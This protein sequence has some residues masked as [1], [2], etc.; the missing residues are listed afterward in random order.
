MSRLDEALR[1]A[2][3]RDATP[4]EPPG[5]DAHGH[6]VDP[7]TFTS[8]W[9]FG[10]GVRESDRQI[11]LA[12][13]PADHGDPIR[14][15]Q[16]QP[17]APEAGRDG[18]S[19]ALMF[20]PAVR[21]RLVVT[22]N[23]SSILAERYR[24]LAGTLHQAQA[25]RALKT[26]MVSSALAGEGKSFTATNLALTL[27]ESYKLQVLLIDADLRR[28]SLHQVFQ[29]ANVA[30][31]NEGLQGPDGRK[32]SV[33]QLTDRL[34]LL[35]AGRPDPDP[36][37]SL[38]SER[39]RRVVTEAAASYDWV[40]LDTPPI[41]LLT[42]ASLLSAMVDAAL[43][44]VRANATPVALVQ[45]AVEALGRDRIFG[46]VLNGADDPLQRGDYYGYRDYGYSAY[47]GRASRDGR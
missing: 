10:E 16:G 13:R 20:H 42:D 7:A 23:L 38:T 45:Q 39:M 44:V 9:D 28:P 1:R 21:E 17:A 6:A 35:P 19:S 36:M 14:E 34:T 15:D 4:G 43:L 29:V 40:I 27:S 18:H 11:R 5:P 47:A 37:H 32:L 26:I 3:G 8:P 25:T 33:L 41:G 31:L 24:R 30:G 12:G 22:E 46:V 2:Q